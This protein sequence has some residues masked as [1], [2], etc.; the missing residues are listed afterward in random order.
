M[1]VNEDKTFG[2]GDDNILQR[3]NSDVDLTIPKD[4][5][6]RFLARDELE[7]FNISGVTLTI[8]KEGGVTVDG[9]GLDII[10]KGFAVFRKVGPNK[11]ISY[12]DLS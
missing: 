1:I 5:T 3:V 8:L 6:F 12:G 7:I 9:K 10:D 4:A 2:G 11:W